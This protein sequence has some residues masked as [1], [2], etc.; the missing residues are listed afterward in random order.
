MSTASRIIQQVSRVLGTLRPEFVKFPDNEDEIKK[1][2][3]NFYNISK[4]SMVIGALE[5]THV[6]IKSRGGDSA[7]AYKN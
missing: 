7:E 5:C 4:F 1:V 2:K 6:K 3:Y